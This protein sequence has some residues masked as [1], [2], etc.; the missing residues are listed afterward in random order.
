MAWTYD[1]LYI[2]TNDIIFSLFE[3]NN[4]IKRRTLNIDD[5]THLFKEFDDTKED[6]K[7][8]EHLKPFHKRKAYLLFHSFW[9]NK[10]AI[11]PEYIYDLINVIKEIYDKIVKE[12]FWEESYDVGIM[13]NE[14]N[15]QIIFHCIYFDNVYDMESLWD[16]I[17]EKLPNKYKNIWNRRKSYELDV[18]LNWSLLNQNNMKIWKSIS[19]FEDSF[20]GIY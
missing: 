12:N 7:L 6:Y 2:N 19:C 10:K 4:V 9:E 15:I 14:N 17:E 20:I 11:E 5:T 1:S 18:S 16:D 13:A 3:E 8:N